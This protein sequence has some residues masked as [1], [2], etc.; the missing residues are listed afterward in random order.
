MIIFF[1]LLLPLLFL[2]MLAGCAT[3]EHRIQKNQEFF[4]TLP[5]A[6]QARIRGGQIDLNFTPGMVRIALGEPQRTLLRRTLTGN[7]EIWLYSDSSRSYERQ[8]ADIDGLVV[9]S[10]AGVRSVGGSV[11]INVPQVR[12]FV[13]LRVEFQNGSVVAI[14]EISKESPKE[15]P[16]ETPKD[17]TPSPPPQAAGPS[18]P[19]PSP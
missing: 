18:A 19:Q 7:T 17:A 1:R 14:E 3:P 13:R 16:K 12:E 15:T 6:A 2:F 8:R 10:S 4:N 9:N 5:V 11:W